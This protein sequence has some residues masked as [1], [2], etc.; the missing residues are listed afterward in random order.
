M[1]YDLN[2]ADLIWSDMIWYDLI[3]SDLNWWASSDEASCMMWSYETSYSPLS[4]RV[5]LKWHSPCFSCE[6]WPTLLSR[7][8]GLY[9]DFPLLT[10]NGHNQ[11]DSDHDFYPS[12]I[13]V[14]TASPG[15]SKMAARGSKKNFGSSSQLSLNKF[16]DLRIPSMRKVDDGG[17]KNEKKQNK[18]NNIMLFILATHIVAS[19]PP[20]CR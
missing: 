4:A 19:R 1:W 2:L 12:P 14:M 5:C 8:F 9:S 17:G 7:V 3:R 18:K 15:K 20:K 16:F 13:A 10:H 6:I 11:G